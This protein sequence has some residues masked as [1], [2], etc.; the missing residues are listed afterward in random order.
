MKQDIYIKK[1]IFLLSLTVKLLSVIS[2]S[3]RVGHV[4]K[5][6]ESSV[7]L[8]VVCVQADVQLSP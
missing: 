8:P 5:A 3:A 6:T 2:F 1:G 4:V 7:I